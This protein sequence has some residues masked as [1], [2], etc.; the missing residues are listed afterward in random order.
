MFQGK[1]KFSLIAP[2]L[3]CLTLVAT[4]TAAIAGWHGLSQSQR[5][6]H[7]VTRASRDLGRN[8]GVE[9]K[10]WVRNVVR[11]V[12][13]VNIPSNANNYTW[14]TVS[15]NHCVRMLKPFPISWVQRGQ[16]I[17]MEWRSRSGTIYPHT[18]TVLS[19]NGTTMTWID[20]N[21]LGDTTVRTHEVSVR[22]FELRVGTNYNVYEIR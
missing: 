17:Q 8:V 5:N 9:C 12:S 10:E 7:I 11:G 2:V 19:N 4:A 1:S 18:A 20:S 6:N 13:N 3:V 14:S 15:S 22:N 16:I 21:W